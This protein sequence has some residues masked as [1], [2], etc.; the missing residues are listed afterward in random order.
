MTAE[1][2]FDIDTSLLNIK[3]NPANRY[4]QFF[5]PEHPLA[6]QN[7]MVNFARHVA[8]RKIRRW[9][10][11]NEVV[12]HGDGDRENCAPA[13]RTCWCSCVRSLPREAEVPSSVVCLL[14]RWSGC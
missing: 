13:A 3:P 14:T 4:L 2:F 6:C 9:L 7:G 8:S 10:T 5:L 12:I 1:D 11:P